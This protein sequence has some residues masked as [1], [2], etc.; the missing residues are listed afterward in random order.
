MHVPPEVKAFVKDAR[1]HKLKGAQGTLFIGLMGAGKSFNIQIMLGAHAILVD[2][3]FT[4][5]S[6]KAIGPRISD[7]FTS[8]TLQMNDYEGPDSNRNFLDTAGVNEG[9]GGVYKL[10]TD[11][12]RAAT[13]TPI[14]RIDATCVVIDYSA[15]AAG[16]RGEGMRKLAVELS[17]S[18]GISAAAAPFYGSMCFVFTRPFRGSP[19]VVKAERILADIKAI[20]AEEEEEA[21]AEILASQ[22]RLSNGRLA[23]VTAA[24]GAAVASVGASVGVAQDKC[25][26]EH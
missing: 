25:T 16:S 4:I 3:E 26:R 17:K 19:T 23:L 14:D 9:R 6:T 13:F 7:Q 5:T 8:T 12:T 21:R 15:T 20:L 22:P 1:W 10:W 24:V 18:V 11:F 2:G